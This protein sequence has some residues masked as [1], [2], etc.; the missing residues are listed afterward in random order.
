MSNTPGTSPYEPERYWA[1]TSKPNEGKLS[2]SVLMGG[3]LARAY[4][5]NLIRVKPYQILYLWKM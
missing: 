1:D 3:K 2:R 4:L 5:S